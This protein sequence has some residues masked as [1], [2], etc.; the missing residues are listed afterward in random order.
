[1]LILK[2]ETGGLAVGKNRIVEDKMDKVN[3]LLVEYRKA[4]EEMVA[5]LK[6]AKEANDRRSD[7]KDVAYSAMNEMYV[8]DEA[9]D[10]WYEGIRK[11]HRDTGLYDAMDELGWS[12]SSLD[13]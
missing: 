2:K 4:T 8:A 6:V 3:E 7:A 1:M 12:S 9:F 10:D 5:A 13:C 11:I